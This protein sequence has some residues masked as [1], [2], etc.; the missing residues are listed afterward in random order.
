[1][2]FAVAASAL[3]LVA[4]GL[5]AA[6]SAGEPSREAAAA[7]EAAFDEGK[8]LAAKRLYEEACAKF[9]ESQRLAPASGTLLNLADCYERLGRTASAWA[10][11]RA[12]AAEA[13][14]RGK[15]ARDEEA[16][17]RAAALEPRLS[18]L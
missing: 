17:A 3:M 15:A 5:V 14:A 13:R 2:R 1:M 11:F 6:A 10:T 7:A 4:L 9:E 18:K 16:R 12:A 8:R